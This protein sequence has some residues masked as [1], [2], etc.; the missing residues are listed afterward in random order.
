M[1]CHLFQNPD[2][3]F[4]GKADWKLELP[5]DLSSCHFTSVFVKV[6]CASSVGLSSSLSW[7]RRSS[8]VCLVQPASPTSSFSS[9]CLHPSL[10]HQQ[11]AHTFFSV[12]QGFH[13]CCPL[14]LEC[15]SHLSWISSHCLKTQLGPSRMNEHPFITSPLNHDFCQGLKE[16]YCKSLSSH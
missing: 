16:A 12:P 11:S 4:V 3:F 5:S 14:H 9:F 2:L 1:K 6:V 7:K 8:M 13:I 10:Q 15:L